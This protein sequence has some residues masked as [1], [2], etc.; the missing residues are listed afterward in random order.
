MACRLPWH[1]DRAR[2]LLNA[3]LDATGYMLDTLADAWTR[4]VV[5]R[6]SGGLH[7]CNADS[8]GA[9]PPFVAQRNWR[10]LTV[11][12]RRQLHLPSVRIVRLRRRRWSPADAT[13]RPNGV[14]QCAQLAARTT[15]RCGKGRRLCAFTPNRRAL[16]LV[17]TGPKHAIASW[18][19][20]AFAG[21]WVWHWKD[22]IDRDYIAKLRRRID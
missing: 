21:R 8:T 15:D 22:R 9:W 17:S 6:T 11:A 16:Y 20:W 19:A 2:S 4:R 3:A 12:S 10:S 14:M 7:R 18:G 5:T 13:P 1:G